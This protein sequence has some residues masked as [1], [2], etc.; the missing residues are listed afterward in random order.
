VKSYD[1]VWLTHL[2]G[3]VHQPLHAVAR[4]T[5]ADASGDAG[6]NDVTLNCPAGLSCEKVL[7]SEWDHLLGDGT[8]FN[9]VKSAATSI[10]TGPAPSGANISDVSVWIQESV[11]LAK[12]HVYKTASGGRWALQRLR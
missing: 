4:F 5:K 1:L 10:D 7:H 3:D 2:V 9:G 6:G 11:T 12:S 8:S